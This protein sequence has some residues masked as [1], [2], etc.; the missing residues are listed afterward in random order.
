MRS[1]RRGERP[2][3]WYRVVGEDD[4]QS[5]QRSGGVL[6][7][8]LWLAKLVQ[9]G[10]NKYIKAEGEHTVDYYRWGVGGFTRYVCMYLCS[11]MYVTGYAY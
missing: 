10:L 8:Q 2:A 3:G 1:R 4:A 7:F 9:E 6:C 5:L 11:R